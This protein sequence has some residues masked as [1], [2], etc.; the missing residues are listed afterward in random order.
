MSA[1]G[2]VVLHQ[3]DGA[4]FR[5]LREA[6][7]ATAEKVAAWTLFLKT[8]FQPGDEELEAVDAMSQ[9]EI[10]HGM[11]TALPNSVEPVQ[12]KAE[13]PGPQFEAF[14]QLLLNE[15]ARPKNMPRN[16]A[17]CDS[18]SYNYASGRLDHQTY[19]AGLDVDR[20]DC[21][22]AVLDPLFKVWF[23]FA[24]RQFGWLGG[25]PSVVGP[26]ARAHK[27][28]WPKHLV[29]DVESEA[30]ANQT[31]LQSGQIFLPQLFAEQGQDFED[32]VEKAAVAFGVT[33]DDIRRRLLDA[34]LKPTI[35]SVSQQSSP[36]PPAPAAAAVL[37]S[38]MN[39]HALNGST[40]E[41]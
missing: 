15:Q 21:N 12:L 3:A 35:A 33:A 32:E 17:G 8:L 31:K 11:M 13:H 2:H 38:R 14:H 39:G 37:R 41:N 6:N 26:A 1:F 19:Y 34:T 28:D 9:L 40:H 4:A 16:K 27:W 10:V 18:S 23:T 20:E 29:A 36:T 7:L 24:V 5:R 30:N 22:D 25:D